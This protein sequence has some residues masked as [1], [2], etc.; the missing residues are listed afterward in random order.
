MSMDLL[1]ASHIRPYLA[2][3][4]AV[5]ALVLRLLAA[6]VSNV[7]LQG[8]PQFVLSATLVTNEGLPLMLTILEVYNQ[9]SPL[10]VRTILDESYASGTVVEKD[11]YSSIATFTTAEALPEASS[12][13]QK[14]VAV[15]N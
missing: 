15:T 10:H 8:P 3:V 11:V 13:R 12:S 5:V 7:A 1:V 14:I 9:T 6:L 2:P 4:I